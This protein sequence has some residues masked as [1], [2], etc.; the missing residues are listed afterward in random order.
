MG[1]DLDFD[2]EAYIQWRAKEEGPNPRLR[3]PGLTR[4]PEPLTSKISPLNPQLCVVLGG[5]LDPK[6]R[7][8]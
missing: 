5:T 3:T 6:P 2:L 4:N 1:G 7:T 8:P